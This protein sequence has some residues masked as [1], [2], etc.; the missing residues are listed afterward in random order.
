MMAAA[1]TVHVSV[2]VAMSPDLDHGVILDGERCHAEPGGG[3]RR[4]G[5][6]RGDRGDGNE[7]EAFHGFLQIA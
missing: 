4:N 5:E 2:A 7:Q 6:N 1:A 3:G